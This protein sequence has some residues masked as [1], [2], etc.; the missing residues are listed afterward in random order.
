MHIIFN[1]GDQPNYVEFAIP[2]SVIGAADGAKAATLYAQLQRS[3]MSLNYYV[4]EDESTNQ[5]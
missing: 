4:K 2:E 1:V 3:L 5:R